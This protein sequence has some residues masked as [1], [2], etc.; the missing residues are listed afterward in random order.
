MF[1][2]VG[3]LFAFLMSAGLFC[4][5]GVCSGCYPCTRL[6]GKVLLSV[7]APLFLTWASVIMYHGL[8]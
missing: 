5:Y 4:R 1:K 7:G 6:A 3:L 8:T 2:W